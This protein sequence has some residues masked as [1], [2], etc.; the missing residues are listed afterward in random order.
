MR[1]KIIF[2]AILIL[3]TLNTF[4]GETAQTGT[5]ICDIADILAYLI[6]GMKNHTTSFLKNLGDFSSIC[7]EYSKEFQVM[8][9]VQF[10]LKK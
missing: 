1:N 8:M 4:N 6:L 5:S 2:G 10:P 9:L 3:R 7:E